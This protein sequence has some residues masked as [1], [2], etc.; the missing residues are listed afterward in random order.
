MMSETKGT[1]GAKEA[2]CL[3]LIVAIRIIQDHGPFANPSGQNVKK[4]MGC[5]EMNVQKYTK[6]AYNNINGKGA[7]QIR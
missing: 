3:V 2:P 6:P 1:L 7:S 5:K 4:G